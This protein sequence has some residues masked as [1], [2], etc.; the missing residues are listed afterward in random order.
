MALLGTGGGSWAVSWWLGVFLAT[1]RRDGGLRLVV[2]LVCFQQRVAFEL[3]E[4]TSAMLVVH[5]WARLVAVVMFVE[6]WR[7][8][9]VA[10]WCL[11]YSLCNG[12]GYGEL[13]CNDC[14]WLWAPK[15]ERAK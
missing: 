3:G 7:S 12:C 14:F 13:A 2:A 11:F 6:W 15:R 10:S 9:K 4:A 8:S 1:L 5:N